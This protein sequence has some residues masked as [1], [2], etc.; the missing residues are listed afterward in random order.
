MCNLMRSKRSLA[1]A[2]QPLGY[3]L[4]VNGLQA[5][6]TAATV[7]EQSSVGVLFRSELRDWESNK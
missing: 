2:A 3:L 7:R 4:Q 6:L 1:Y 5:D